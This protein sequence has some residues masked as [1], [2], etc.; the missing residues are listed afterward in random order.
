[1]VENKEYHNASLF[2]DSTGM[3][4]GSSSLIL[5]RNCPEEDNSV[6]F[7]LYKVISLLFLRV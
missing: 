2:I 3:V 5:E 4:K 1:M 6:I 7:L